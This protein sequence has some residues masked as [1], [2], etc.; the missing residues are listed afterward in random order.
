[1][2]PLRHRFSELPTNLGDVGTSIVGRGYLARKVDPT[3]DTNAGATPVT[4]GTGQGAVQD[5]GVAA[6]VLPGR[7]LGYLASQ[8]A[9]LFVQGEVLAT[10]GLA[11]VLRAGGGPAFEELLDVDDSLDWQS[12]VQAGNWGRIDVVGFG[13]AGA[14]A[15]AVEA[16]IHHWL[17]L[18]Q[19][20]SYSSW[21]HEHAD[22]ARKIVVLLVPR[23]RRPEA[24]GVVSCLD[25]F[26]KVVTWEE[27][28]EALAKADL[29]E[30]PRGDLHQLEDFYHYVEGSYIRPFSETE[31]DMAGAAWAEREEDLTRLAQQL[32]IELPR[33]LGAF[34][35]GPVGRVQPWQEVGSAGYRYVAMSLAPGATNLA[36]GVFP[37]QQRWPFAVR[38]HADTGFF[39]EVRQ[40]LLDEPGLRAEQR[41][42][43]HV[44]VPLRVP[45]G[46]AHEA[47]V[48]AVYEQ[49][50][51]VI[52]A[53]TPELAGLP[54]DRH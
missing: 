44:Y 35:G 39:P 4:A 24:E 47:M 21:L 53:A 22:S 20:V 54:I 12:E 41:D 43:G 51:R 8:R 32:T 27:V 25:R 1:M 2:W 16:K 14:R 37:W 9:E 45:P 42:D 23:A 26:A 50:V 17:S 5:S 36:V 31:A 30:G 11:W 29:G 52:R 28:F 49:V 33:A 6:N 3:C 46:A 15:V 10:F 34:N 18:E 13:E 19:L 40:R 38:Y 48:D 7:L